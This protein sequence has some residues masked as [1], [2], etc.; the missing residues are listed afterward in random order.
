MKKR[1]FFPLFYI[2]VTL[3]SIALFAGCSGAGEAEADKTANSKQAVERDKAEKRVKKY[4]AKSQSATF[5]NL[6]FF[7]CSLFLFL[8]H[9]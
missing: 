5:K 1:R 8:I 3:F 7:L 6:G 9:K 2:I 4:L